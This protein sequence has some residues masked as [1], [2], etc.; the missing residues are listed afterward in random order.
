[1]SDSNALDA[2]TS[3][4]IERGEL[5]QFS[6][7]APITEVVVHARGA[8]VTRRA[9]LPDSIPDGA[10]EIVCRGVT[11]AAETSG[12]RCEVVTGDR[13][14]TG[15]RSRLD[16][17]EV[18]RGP[19]G[20]RERVEELGRQL[21][22][23]TDE[24]DA[25]SKRVERLLRCR[26]QPLTGRSLREEG[27][28]SRTAAAL[29]ASD[30]VEDRLSAL[31]ERLAEVERAH[32]RISKER[33]AAI[34]AD[35]QASNQPSEGSGDP[36]RAVV[37]T[38]GAGSSPTVV[39]FSYVVRTA[40]WWPLYTLRVDDDGRSASLLVE[41]QVAQATGEDWDAVTIGFSTSEIVRDV[42][43]PTLPSF[44]LGRAQPEPRRGFRP[45]PR[46]V[47]R[48]FASFDLALS[49]VVQP[50]SRP[51]GSARGS[52]G[53][54]APYD[55][56]P[57][58]MQ[59]L[60]E[61]G[62]AEE[63]TFEE[64]AADSAFAE[65]E[66][67]P[68]ASRSRSLMKKSRPPDAAPPPASTSFAGAPQP[69]T[70][71]PPPAMV[72]GGGGGPGGAMPSD[73]PAGAVEPSSEWLDFDDVVLAPASAADRGKLRRKQA[74]SG[75][76]PA[77]IQGAVARAEQM[78]AV[79]PWISRG[80]YDHRYDAEAAVDVPAD[81]ALHRVEIVTAACPSNLS[82]RTNPRTESAVYREVALDNPHPSPLLAGPL[83]VYVRGS[84]VANTSTPTVDRGGSMNVGLGVD[85][86]LKVARNARVREESAGLL[87]GKREIDHFVD[88]EI[89]SSLG[90]DAMVEL[91]DRIPVSKDE[92]V[93]VNLFECV[94]EADEYDQTDRDAPVEGG[95]RWRVEVFAGDTV[96]VRF[97]YRIKLRAKDELIGG[98]RRE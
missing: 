89:A 26:I 48:L 9:E 39:T 11:M 72:A 54:H 57:E 32:R 82:W 97:A 35:S 16:I 83:D 34:I 58:A 60:G 76:T 73:S 38:M 41:A 85:E 55:A 63:S 70:G 53:E 86:R 92:H 40:R 2:A 36:S 77:S 4:S 50:S 17:P 91:I 84:L 75:G 61:I 46:G 8:L 87:G 68:A 24:H 64:I 69:Q 12:L 27:A 20:T 29:D 21:R 3:S 52:S 59:Q 15:I 10:I 22:R 65:E 45:P 19:G 6:V 33:E 79:D 47:E 90:F 98:N 93:E 81:G 71:A 37:M 80:D 31:N 5:P 51:R 13:L 88:I 56:H 78:G 14:V 18:D 96:S 25:I 28:A 42:Q 44:R 43:L 95:L 67:F 1:M 74:Q 49:D 66:S 7:E 23:L 94:P 30:I 62:A